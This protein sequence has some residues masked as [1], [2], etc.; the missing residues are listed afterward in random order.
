MML[1]VTFY[2]FIILLFWSL[3]KAAS[4]ED[5]Y[6]DIFDENKNKMK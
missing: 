1:F 2:I 5:K 3:C 4:K 6:Y